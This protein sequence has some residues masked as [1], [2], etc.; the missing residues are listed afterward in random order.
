MQA[1]SMKVNA[2]NAAR[3]FMAE[4]SLSGDWSDHF[5]IESKGPRQYVVEHKPVMNRDNA[6]KSL[7]VATE[8]RFEFATAAIVEACE[9]HNANEARRAA[10]AFFASRPAPEAASEEEVD[11]VEELRAAQ[12][13]ADAK[14]NDEQANAAPGSKYP[15]GWVHKS[16]V[17]KPVKRVWAIA[18]EMIAANPNV[19]R[20]EVQEECV[21]RGIASG[22]ARTQYQA[23]KTARDAAA[24]NAERAAELSAKFNQQ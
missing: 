24:K 8:G 12:A 9:F 19:T 5:V 2:I 4:Q 13:A 7:M 17:L 22:T 15:A 21:R 6:W 10:A 20:K 3:R 18:D 1:Y 11:E 14:A 23:W 16:A